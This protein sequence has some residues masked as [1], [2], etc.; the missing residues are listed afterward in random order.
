MNT[1]VINLETQRRA[2]FAKPL[3]LMPDL[4]GHSCLIDFGLGHERHPIL[5]WALLDDQSVSGMIIH[6][7][8]LAPVTQFTH[9]FEGYCDDQLERVH[10]QPPSFLKPSLRAASDHF[11][12]P[13]CVQCPDMAELSVALYESD[14]WSFKR[15][16]MWHLQS[17]DIAPMVDY[18]TQTQ[19]GPKSVRIDARRYSS[20]AGL[21]TPAQIGQ[22]KAGG[23]VGMDFLG[24]LARYRT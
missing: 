4:D 3:R 21:V 5:A 19:Q 10:R 8:T 12:S 16:Q 2:R 23:P 24:L 7:G 11:D 15:L 22:L 13:H 1:S 20:Y 18:Q 14:H 17:G 9:R 6:E